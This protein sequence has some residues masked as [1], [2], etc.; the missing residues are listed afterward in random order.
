MINVTK[1]ANPSA[2]PS[3]PGSVTY[4]YLVTNTGDLP[5]SHIV[6]A[7]NKCALITFMSGDRNQ[8]SVLELDEIW[9]YRC[10]QV[11]AKSTTN[12]ATV[13]GYS[14]GITVRDT[15]VARVTVGAVSPSPSPFIP[16]KFPNAGV[17]SDAQNNIWSIANPP[18]RA[19]FAFIWVILM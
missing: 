11:L 14:E 3:G 19:L 4:S 17:Y 7:D 15:A 8:N 1:T 10:T 9:T 2:L 16:P 5:L 6:L 18:L 12:V 13:T